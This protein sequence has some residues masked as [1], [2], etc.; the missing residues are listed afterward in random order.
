MKTRPAETSE[1][2]FLSKLALRSKSLHGYGNEYIEKCRPA[3]TIDDEY[4][5]EWPVMVVEENDLI[6]GFFALKTINGENRLDHLWLEP[7][8]TGKGIGRKVFAR[9]VELAESKGWNSFRIVADPRSKGFYTKMGAVDIGMTQ[10]RI[11]PDIQ[12]PHMEFI[13]D[14]PT[15]QHQ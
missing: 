12:L 8:C 13:I 2:P 1:G 10:S 11:A 3:L 6:A 5:N 15:Y 4:I 9:I 7:S 14:C